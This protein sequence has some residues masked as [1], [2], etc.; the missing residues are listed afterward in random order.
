MEGDACLLC[1]LAAPMCYP[2]VGPETIR[3]GLPSYV[4]PPYYAQLLP[5]FSFL[6]PLSTSNFAICLLNCSLLTL[7]SQWS[8]TMLILSQLELKVKKWHK[9]LNNNFLTL[10]FIP[11]LV[12]IQVHIITK[13]HPKI[14]KITIS[15]KLPKT[16]KNHFSF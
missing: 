15:S 13:N 8:S 12:Y 7:H 11:H 6:N 1:L 16:S 5:N 2:C 9:S 14:L 10:K 3:Q 4:G